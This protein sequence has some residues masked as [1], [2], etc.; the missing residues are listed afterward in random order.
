MKKFL[1]SLFAIFV[2]CLAVNAQDYQ[3]EAYE[4]K[5]CTDEEG[6]SYACPVK[7][8]IFINIDKKKIYSDIIPET[9]KLTISGVKKEYTHGQNVTRIYAYNTR[10]T[11]D[12]WMIRHCVLPDG[13]I[14]IYFDHNNV[15][16]VY[17]VRARKWT[18]EW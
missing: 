17:T 13:R 6:W 2:S 14:K 15:T 5:Y 3:Y 10:N 9:L 7:A 1:I 8:Q 4:Y 18:V 16:L 12:E 11:R